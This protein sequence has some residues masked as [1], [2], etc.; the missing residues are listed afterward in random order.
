PFIAR[1]GVAQAA[2]P[3]ASSLVPPMVTPHHETAAPELQADERPVLDLHEEHLVE[4][5]TPQAAEE[6]LLTETTQLDE[7][8]PAELLLTEPAGA[9]VEDETP[10][11]L[12]TELE[13]AVGD[14]A[15]ELL[16]TD[17]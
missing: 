13:P 17:V 12:L 8:A 9:E 6:L 11:L 10:E 5:T 3:T 16:L 4:T 1:P 2:A 7:D 15:E 14:A